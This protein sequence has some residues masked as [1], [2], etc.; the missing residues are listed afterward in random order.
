MAAWLARCDELR[1]H[2][3]ALTPDVLTLPCLPD[4]WSA[5]QAD[6]Q[7]LIR[8]DAWC[9]MAV[10]TVACGSTRGLGNAAA[11]RLLFPTACHPRPGARSHRRMC[12]LWRRRTRRPGRSVYVRGPL[13]KAS[14]AAGRPALAPTLAAAALML[15]WSTNAVLDHLAL[16][17]RADAARR[18]AGRFIASGSKTIKR[19]QPAPADAA[20]PAP[21]GSDNRRLTAGRPYSQLA[22]YGL[23][24]PGIQLRSLTGMPRAMRFSSIFRRF[25]HGRWSS[26]PPAHRPVFACGQE[27]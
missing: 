8:R 22:K 19:Y 7:W 20:A 12:S 9:G 27:K 1:L 2:I 17:R 25:L 24:H 3:L 11:D 26:S 15:L 4:R 13:R 18:P 5:V 23:R 10:E 16:S 21:A 6:D 14:L